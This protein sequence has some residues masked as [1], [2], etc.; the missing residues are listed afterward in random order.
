MD[1][2]VNFKF[3]YY[4]LYCLFTSLFKQISTIIKN[5]LVNL[6]SKETEKKVTIEKFDANWNVTNPQFIIENFSIY[7]STSEK[8]LLLKI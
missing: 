7:A 4:C 1:F 8:A 5:E 6:I 2:W 3:I